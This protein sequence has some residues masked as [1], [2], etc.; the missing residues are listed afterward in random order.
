MTTIQSKKD[1]IIEEYIVEMNRKI[2]IA[3]EKLKALD[4]NEHGPQLSMI[5]RNDI[6][7]DSDIVFNC[8][9]CCRP[10]I[11]DSRDHDECYTDIE[12]DGDP[13]KWWCSDCHKEEYPEPEI[14]CI[15]C[16]YS[17]GSQEYFNSGKGRVAFSET[18]DGVVIN[19]GEHACSVC[20]K[21]V[22]EY[23]PSDSDADSL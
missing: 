6:C 4:D 23:W 15:C 17:W 10:I 16:D 19:D 20:V 9:R 13:N 21:G 14:T 5:E 2:N 11:R 1:A 8:C 22:S 18:T 12:G 7:I 3:N